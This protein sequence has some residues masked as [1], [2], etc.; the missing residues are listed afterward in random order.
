MAILEVRL[1]VDCTHG[2]GM[3]QEEAEELLFPLFDS[4]DLEFKLLGRTLTL[5]PSDALPERRGL[6]LIRGGKP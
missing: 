1:H 5:E 3:S 6:T 2:Y 4:G